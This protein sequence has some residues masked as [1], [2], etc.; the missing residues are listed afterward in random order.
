MDLSCRATGPEL[1]DSPD[2]SPLDLQHALQ[3]LEAVNRFL[4]GY[5]P[6]LRGLQKV[7][8]TH[9][10]S[11]TFLDV[12][13]GS[14]D[15]LR[16]IAEWARRRK[17]KAQLFGIELSEITVQRAVDECSAYSEISISHGNL[18]TLESDTYDVV[19]TAL[20]M[21]H[22]TN[23][24]AVVGLAK[25]AE[26]ARYGIIVNDLH[27]HPF[28]YH[29]IRL[30]TR[31]LSRSHVL[32]NDAPLSVARAFTRPELLK[33]AGAAGLRSVQLEWNW[34]FR[35]LLTARGGAIL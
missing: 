35:W 8:P 11:F 28:A 20:V 24:E 29:S 3:H 31:L 17:L 25:M 6:S 30:L 12:G 9:A 1:M 13:C 15:T 34:A 23:E 26:L 10:R 14:G 32:R 4:N 5:G 18:F 21:H 7:M 19:H 2:I 22:L 27:R 33:M 16:R